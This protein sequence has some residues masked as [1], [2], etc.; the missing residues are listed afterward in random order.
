L[1]A[2]LRRRLGTQAVTCRP[3]RVDLPFRMSKRNCSEIGDL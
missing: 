2:R 1:V 3:P